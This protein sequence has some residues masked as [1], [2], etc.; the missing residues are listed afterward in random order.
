MS[1]KFVS[2]ISALS[3]AAAAAA[4]PAA[5]TTQF[6][7]PT[8]YLSAADSPF[9]PASYAQFYLE[10]FEDGLINTPGL[11][12][13]GMGQFCVSNEPGCFQNS[14]LIDSVGNGGNG[15]VGHSLFDG[16][17]KITLTFD[18]NAL[19][20]LPTAAGLVWTDGSNPIHFEAFDQ[21]GVSLGSL[22]GNSADN[23]F[24]GGTAEDRFYGVTNTG[25]IS[26]LIITDQTGIEIDHVQ[27][28]VDVAAPGGVPEPAA[29]A[30]MLTGFFGA[31]ATIRARRRR[32]RLA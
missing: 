1:M 13:A 26:K 25:G 3:L 20:A 19:G 8:A 29:W 11:G 28:G 18:A 23:S 12:A 24:A 32:L 6:F 5:A 27:Y 2:A 4:S 14:G 31:G 17:G 21:N 9:V 7:G 16:E 10:D 15:N 30:L 22:I